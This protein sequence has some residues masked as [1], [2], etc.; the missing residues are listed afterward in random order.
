LAQAPRGAAG[1]RGRRHPS[2]LLT[3]LAVGAD[4]VIDSSR[5]EVTARLA[6]LHGHST[7]ALGAPRP[8]TGIYIDAAGAAAVVNTALRGAKW[9]ARLVTVAVNKSPSRSTWA[10]CCAA[11]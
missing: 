11:R 10:R 8:D 6:G 3:A 1:G 5:E 9:G 2:R 7:N 4:A